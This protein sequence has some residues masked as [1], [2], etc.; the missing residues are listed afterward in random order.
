M[1]RELGYHLRVENDKTAKDIQDLVA[2]LSQSDLSQWSELLTT[3]Q[4]TR[5][6]ILSPHSF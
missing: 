5:S 6:L 1:F 4:V 3:V 2:E